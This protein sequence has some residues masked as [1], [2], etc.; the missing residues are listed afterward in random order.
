MLTGW[1][2]EHAAAVP[3]RDER[4]VRIV[5]DVSDGHNVATATFQA[6]AR[7]D[8]ERAGVLKVICSHTH[9]HT[10]AHIHTGNERIAQSNAT[11][12]PD[13]QVRSL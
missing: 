12:T 13:E 1:T 5:L 10:Y 7:P 2:R 9:T 6:R 11:R 4:A 8:H 3:G